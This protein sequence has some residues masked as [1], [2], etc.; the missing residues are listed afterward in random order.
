[1]PV[2]QQASWWVMLR[3]EQLPWCQRR[4]CGHTTSLPSH[5]EALVEAAYSLKERLSAQQ[6]GLLMDVQ[7]LVL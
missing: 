2:Q 6:M 3:A 5:P 4:V 1:M 7:Q